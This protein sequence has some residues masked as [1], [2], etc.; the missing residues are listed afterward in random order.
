MDHYPTN[1]HAAK[2]EAN[3]AN[4]SKRV[5]RII[6]GTVNRRK[7]PLGQRFFETFVGGDASSV[8]SYVLGEVLI[9]A[10]KDV[11]SDAITQG[12]DRMLF[13]DSRPGGYRRNSRSSSGYVNYNRYSPPSSNWGSNRDR[14]RNHD[15]SRRARASHDFDEIILAT[16]PEAEKVLDRLFDLISNY[17]F[18]SVA[19]LYELVGLTGS[20]VDDNWGWTDLRGSTV[21][22]Y[23]D[24]YLLNLP[25]TEYL[26][27]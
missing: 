22:R 20:H 24:G 21:R 19:D 23:R 7:K 9:P 25:K 1:S 3:E 26:G 4:N 6:T 17:E 14:P 18:A 11:I 15:I 5:E 16:R 27:E 2:K 10:A 13:G 8:W 12:I